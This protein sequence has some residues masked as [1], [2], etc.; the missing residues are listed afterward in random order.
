MIEQQE[1]LILASFILKRIFDGQFVAAVSTVISSDQG[2][3][4][5]EDARICHLS[6]NS[7]IAIL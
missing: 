1:R 6:S 3:L 5:I 7:N 4:L 2:D